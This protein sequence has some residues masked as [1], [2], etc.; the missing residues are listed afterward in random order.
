MISS[1]E[2]LILLIHLLPSFVET[3][4]EYLDPSSVPDSYDSISQYHM[5]LGQRV[6]AMGYRKLGGKNLSA[7]KKCGRKEVECNLTFAGFI[8]LD[9]P[10]KPDT[11]KV[12]KELRKSGHDTVMITGDAI[13][14]AA[15][16]ARQVGIIKVKAKAETYELRQIDYPQSS[17][18][19]AQSG[20]KF[21]FVPTKGIDVTNLDTEKCIA[22]TASNLKV[23]KSMLENSSIAAVCVTGDTLTKIATDAVRKKMDSKDSYIDPK[24]VLL[25]PDAQSTLINLV[26][27]ISVFARHAPRQKVSSSEQY[28]LLLSVTVISAQIVLLF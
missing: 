17:L 10:L 11:K 14:T 18:Q 9:C 20:S 13:L 22:Y 25:H 6:L 28:P 4:K 26:P 21:A 23:L 15:E 24:T 16:V 2:Y 1:N 27:L 19:D 3:L 5:S 7:W 12:I 8:V